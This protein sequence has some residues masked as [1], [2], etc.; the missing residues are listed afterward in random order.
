MADAGD[1][2]GYDEEGHREQEAAAEAVAGGEDDDAAAAAEVGEEGDEDGVIDII[3]A[4][5]GSETQSSENDP[6]ELMGSDSEEDRELNSQRRSHML[7]TMTF[8]TSVP[9]V[10][11]STALHQKLALIKCLCLKFVPLLLRPPLVSGRD[12]DGH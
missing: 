12:A 8:D 11:S 3:D 7:S 10:Q 2:G 4:A 9:G 1:E 5:T 6:M